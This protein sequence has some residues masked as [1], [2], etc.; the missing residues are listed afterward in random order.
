MSNKL[1][2]PPKENSK[3]LRFEVRLNQ[4]QVDILNE[5]AENLKIS[6]TDV[7]IRGIELVKEKLDKNK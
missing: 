3:K 5:C 4:E 7:V 1:G 6:K 2:R